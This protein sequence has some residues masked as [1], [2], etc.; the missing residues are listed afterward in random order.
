M[1]NQL[2][3]DEIKA[4]KECG[5]ILKN[6]LDIVC[7]NLGPGVSAYDLDQIAEKEIRKK[8]AVPAFKNY[9]IRGMGSY[10][11]SLCVS[12]NN[13]VVHGLPLKSKIFKNGDIASLDIGAGYKGVY[14][15]MAVTLAVG[16]IEEDTRRL[17]ETTEKALYKGIA[18]AKAGNT[19]GDVGYAIGSY[20]ENFG[21]GVIRDLVGHGIGRKPHLPPQIPNY[22]EKGNGIILVE[23]MA[24][25]IEP[26]FTLGSYDIVSTE[27]GWTIE[28][29]DG[30]LSAHFEHTIVI[31]NGR[32]TIV[33]A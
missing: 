16:E 14:T 25:A 33:T 1:E 21:L 15:D 24:L 26:M 5:A 22:G 8:G 29:A 9:Y 4:I 32:P 19:L 27:D 30:S 2:K 31:E 11:A 17:I 6:S 20:G 12:V 13:E 28:T 18:Q 23:G 10:P 3:R 7:Q